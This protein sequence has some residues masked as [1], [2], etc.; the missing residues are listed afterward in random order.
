MATKMIK[1]PSKVEF[2]CTV[3]LA[4]HPRGEGKQ[5]RFSMV[6]Y[7]GDAVVQG[8]TP[9][10][11]DLASTTVDREKLPM[12]LGHDRTKIAGQAE[13]ITI[14]EDI[15]LSGFITESSDAGKE[16]LGLAGDGFEWQAS[17]FA[18]PG[19]SKFI[20]EGEEVEVNSRTFSGPIIVL[21]DNKILETS[22][23]AVGADRST[24]VAVLSEGETVIEIPDEEPEMADK[25]TITE[26]ELAFPKNSEFVLG[27]L[28]KEMTIEEAQAAFTKSE[29]KRLQADNEKMQAR[30]QKLEDAEKA[31]LAEDDEKKKE[32]EELEGNEAVGTDDDKKREKAASLSAAQSFSAD[33][34]KIEDVPFGD[35]RDK[36]LS[37]LMLKNKEGHAACIA[38]A[39]DGADLYADYVASARRGGE[40]R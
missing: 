31:R 10:V 9:F 37:S 27:A 17:I 35:K 11:L 19:A 12:L 2:S 14:D 6:A 29:N 24:Q 18:V 26:L 33:L 39:N 1:V 7:S 5:R 16:V 30:V 13:E 23:V 28:K 34:A 20:D 22:F 3:V 36:A 32:E 8:D 15:R 4:D 40:R 38:A 21:K 25:A